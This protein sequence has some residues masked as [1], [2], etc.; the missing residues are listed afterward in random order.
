MSQQIV[1]DNRPGAA[2]SIGMELIA[3][4]AADGYTI[5]YGT[6]AGLAINRSLLSKLPYDP[7]KDFQMVALMGYSR[8]FS[9][10]RFRCR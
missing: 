7:D 8:T 6:S 3:R 2:G 5:G 9:Q 1:V 4:A 10:W